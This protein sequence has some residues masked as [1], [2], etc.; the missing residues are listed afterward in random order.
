M[1]NQD[2]EQTGLI[3]E[4][5]EVWL[6]GIKPGEVMGVNWEGTDQCTITLP[7]RLPVDLESQ[8]MLLP[9]LPAGSK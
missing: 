6:T 9:C 3:G 7:T 5:G 8:K 4:D 1:I 2:K